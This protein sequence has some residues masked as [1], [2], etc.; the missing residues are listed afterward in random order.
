MPATRITAVAV[1]RTAASATA[2]AVAGS[3]AMADVTAEDV[4]TQWQEALGSYGEGTLTAGDES[5]EGDTLT[6]SDIS[7]EMEEE[8]M[9]VS[10]QIGTVSFTENGDGTVTVTLPESY[11]V[12]LG[13][14]G[15]M[16]DNHATLT[17]TN[18]GLDVQVSGEPEEI[19]YDI[20]ADSYTIE[21]TE[22][23]DAGETVPG[24]ATATLQGFTGSAMM[25]T[26]G[27][28]RDLDAEMSADMLDLLVDVDVP[29]EMVVDISGK[30]ENISLTETM[31]TPLEMDPEQPEMLMESGAMMDLNVEAG[32]SALIFAY[33]D[34]SESASG[35]YSAAGS[36]LAM[37]VSADRFTL[38]E[39]ATDMALQLQSEG[40]PFPVNVTLGELG[41][42][43]DMPLS[44]SE[45]AED[46]SAGF[47][48][49][50]L[51]VNEELWM[52][53]DP[54]GALPRDPASLIVRFSGSGRLDEDLANPT[55]G[56]QEMSQELPGEIYDLSIDELT[57]RLVGAALSGT[58]S[59]TFDN[60]D[61]TTFEGMPR[62]EGSATFRIEGVNTLLGQLAD[63]GLIPPDQIMGARMMLGLF[64]ESVGEDE[65]ESRIEVTPEGSV[66]ANGQQLR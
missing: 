42:A 34:G 24:E 51:T 30:F 40:I 23:V 52:M 15:S 50:E 10:S 35:A 48:I 8:D 57:L 7:L 56:M 32:Q 33:D 21:L 22:I 47:V 66:L 61:L 58:G 54:S 9:A 14:P 65:L 20:T 27:E 38:D 26:D 41:L 16:E 29:G 37:A 49:D 28:M 44:A 6:V 13:Q 46:F 31:R 5:R 18:S 2:L 45:E 55:G 3:A 1:A 36:R 62:P 53:A 39:G 60:S 17:V 59:F 19:T 63:M 43:I 64:A 4:W 25:A 11:D 12:M